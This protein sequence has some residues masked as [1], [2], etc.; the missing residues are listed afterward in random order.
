MHRSND[1][2]RVRARTITDQLGAKLAA[3]TARK[4]PGLWELAKIFDFCLRDS[5]GAFS[6]STNLCGK[7]K[8]F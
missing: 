4:A 7:G 6:K 2:G 8:V 3:G 1:T 5:Q